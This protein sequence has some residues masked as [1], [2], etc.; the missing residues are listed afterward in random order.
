[1]HIQI[2]RT[3]GF[4]G[5]RKI[6]FDSDKFDSSKMESL[7]KAAMTERETRTHIRD[8]FTFSISV[9]GT[10]VKFQTISDEGSDLPKPVKDLV[11]YLTRRRAKVA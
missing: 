3:G 10:T 5:I 8:C 9:N 11:A 2:T 4:A 1:M 7:V 6:L